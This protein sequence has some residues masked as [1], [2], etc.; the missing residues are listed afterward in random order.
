M[1]ALGADIAAELLAIEVPERVVRVIPLS[2]P[3]AGQD[4]APVIVPGGSIWVLLSAFGLYGADAT[5][6][7]RVPRLAIDDG[8]TTLET[9]QIGTNI[10]AS[11]FVR[12]T[13]SAGVGWKDTSL[14]GRRI[15]TG[16]PYRRL[17]PGWRISITTDAIQAGDQWSQLALQVIDVSTGHAERELRRQLAQAAGLLPEYPGEE[18]QIP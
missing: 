18:V 1:A 4:P 8:T 6:A 16:I 13:W 12:V 10:T 3:A 11:L 15:A 17:Y 14:L 2:Q 9:W 7:N 5:A